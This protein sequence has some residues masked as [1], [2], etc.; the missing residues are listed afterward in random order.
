MFRRRVFVWGLACAAIATSARAQDV[1]RQAATRDAALPLTIEQAV[2]A[3]LD[4]NLSLLAER[5]N[6]KAADAAIL[7]AALRP[8]PVITVS[9][10]RPDQPL[11][12][13][14]LSTYEQVFRTDYI[15]EGGG[16]RERRVDQ[17]TLA[18]S[19]VEQ[20]LRNTTRLL[21]LDVE[22][23]FIDVQLAKLNLTLARDS[24]QAFDDV[25][26]VNADRVR[27]GDLAQ[28]ELSRSSLAALQFQ[29]DVRQ[30][31]MKLR[32]ARNRLSSLIG[33]G[34]DGDTL[35]VAGD[36]RNDPQPVA[37]DAIRREALDRRP[38]LGAVRRDQARNAADLRLQLA[39]GRIDYTV[40]GEYHREE[41]MEIHGNSYLVA[42]SVPLPIFNRN[43]GEV[44]R[45]QVQ[46]EQIGTRVRA[47]ENDISNEVANAYATYA[48]TR[49]VVN[50]IQQQ[51]LTQAR[52]V[53]ATTEY[54]YR[55]GEATFVEFLDAERAYNDTMQSYNGARA[56]YA[57]SLYA[58]DSI[59]GR[60][61]P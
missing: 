61:N 44:A 57:R 46:Q 7:T 2:R 9:A 19:M 27:T 6:V 60:G 50:T 20:Q 12:D 34:P 31:E 48:S 59:A 1:A 3:A 58:I 38:D 23:A 13:S 21:V 10:A 43:Q 17:A 5:Y 42:L 53:R 4:S 45:A 40:S 8:N 15:I 41:G 55:R 33:R 14:G 37:L 25:V 56:E 28:V 30:Q 29:N 24:L 16:K 52:E 39:N 54:S 18:K 35:D 51:M 49:E 22:S 47:L 36:L 11:V 26:R 32:V